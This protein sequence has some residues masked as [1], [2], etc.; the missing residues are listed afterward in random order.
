V[1]HAPLLSRDPP[2]RKS[3]YRLIIGVFFVD[4]PP[5]HMSVRFGV[6][7]GSCLLRT[8]L[9]TAWVP[10]IVHISVTLFNVSKEFIDKPLSI[11]FHFSKKTYLFY[12]ASQV[13]TL[14]LA[15]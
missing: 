11:V 2:A 4:R 15:Y 6:R 5:I 10:L 7:I 12:P 9:Q 13:S 14:L 1:Q 8:T 3:A